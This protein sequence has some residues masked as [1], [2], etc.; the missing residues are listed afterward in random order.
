[1]FDLAIVGGGI[2]GAWTAYHA[3][4]RHPDWDIVLLEKDRVGRGA[5]F[6]AANLDL[7]Y[8]HTE[9]RREMTVFSQ[10][11][12]AELK[13]ELPEISRVEMP[14]WGFTRRAELAA[15]RQCYTV[16][17][18]REALPEEITQL[19]A[20][21]PWM[22]LGEEEAGLTGTT[23]FRA[24]D[25]ETPFHLIAHLVRHHGLQLR[26]STPVLDIA[27]QSG[28]FHLLT[29]W[30]EPVAARSVILTTGPW[31]NRGY[32]G[33]Q[34]QQ[35]QRIKKVAAFHLDLPVPKGAPTVYFFHEDLFFLPRPEVDGWLVSYRCDEW[36]VDPEGGELGIRARDREVISHLLGQRNPNLP[37]RIAGAQVFC[38][39]YPP[40]SNP[41]IFA[42]QPPQP[43]VVAGGPGGS[44]YRLAPAIGEE[45]VAMVESQLV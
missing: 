12:F 10:R 1:M 34:I 3:A 13:R 22:H 16:P 19:Q 11:C 28:V 29:P 40:D 18:V 21:L 26:E 23:C 8:G 24:A 5:S 39:G 14:F 42:L 35:R 2:V 27:E 6:Y 7:P 32:A 25:A 15:L 41:L 38:D 9:K 20:A 33:A 4:H 44:G 30:T 37:P 43:L 36:D 31:L 17:G 45:A